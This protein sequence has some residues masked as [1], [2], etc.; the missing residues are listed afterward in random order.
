MLWKKREIVEMTRRC[1]EKDLVG[2]L[3]FGLQ[4]SLTEY[5]HVSF[6]FSKHSDNPFIY[7]RIVEIQNRQKL[8][9]ILVEKR[10]M[11]ID[12]NISTQSFITSRKGMNAKKI[13]HENFH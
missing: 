1:G 12:E 13:K 8:K 3:I 6:T 11:F 7:Y 2:P 5:S 4:T 9:V 10:K